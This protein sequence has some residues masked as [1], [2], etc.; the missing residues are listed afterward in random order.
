MSIFDKIEKI[1]PETFFNISQP[2]APLISIQIRTKINTSIRLD[3]SSN[4]TEVH[5][6]PG[7]NNYFNSAVIEDQGGMQR[8]VLS[9]F[10]K[11]FANLENAFIQSLMATKLSNTLV[12][13]EVVQD[14]TGYF[15]FKIDNQ[16]MVNIRIRF[17]YSEILSKDQ[18]IDTTSFKDESFVNRTKVNKTVIRSPWIYLQM[19][20]SKFSLKEEG[21][22][23]EITAI[24]V[25]DSFLSRAKLLRRFAVLRG[26]PR[27]IIESLAKIIEKATNGN[28][29]YTIEEPKVPDT[30]NGEGLIEIN[31]GSQVNETSRSWRTMDS[32]LTEVMNK[33]PSRNYGENDVQ[34]TED[35]ESAA[36]E[37]VSKIIPYR[38]FVSQ[39]V[40]A[41]GKLQTKMDFKY[42]DPISNTQKKMRTYVWKEYGQSIVKGLDIQSS[43]DFASL[44]AQVLSVDYKT[45][46]VS[47]SVGRS[48]SSD[49]TMDSESS[50]HLGSIE[51][52]TNSLNNDK[53][54]YTF[55]SDAI[56]VDGGGESTIG[57][58]VARSVVY[59]LNQGVFK[60]TIE[61]MGDPFYLFDSYVSPFQYMIR[62]IINRPAYLD[63]KEQYVG[64]SISYLSG[65]Y[66]IQKITHT[67]NSSGF[68][69]NLEVMRWPIEG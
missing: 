66:A 52:V 25:I 41:S 49:G 37:N 7:M 59:N 63:D 43:F 17:G 26:K 28:F 67:I 9:F 5:L 62:I 14:D 29:E 56:G 38:Y 13:E 31:L 42:P 1:Y 58:R 61:L 68:T 23:V 19:I 46:Q 36:L 30:E 3:D 10:D 24:S 22:Y 8:V 69:T 64:N 18:F 21:L 60:G 53:Y 57:A 44:N 48:S 51:D 40:N 35:N 34:N 65:Y 4:W 32:I 15:Q 6:A 55:V 20:D 45:N 11:N 54:K 47:L 12:Q 50:T 27:E 39:Y 33:I 2:D 16:S